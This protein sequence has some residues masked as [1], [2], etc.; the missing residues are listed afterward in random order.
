MVG[1][2]GGTVPRGNLS[3]GSGSDNPAEGEEAIRW[4]LDD[5]RWM[6]DDDDEVDVK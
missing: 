2:R 5:V 6:D 3:S 1:L 4:D